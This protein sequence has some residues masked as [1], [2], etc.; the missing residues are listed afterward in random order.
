LDVVAI[1]KSP[2]FTDNSLEFISKLFVV[3]IQESLPPLGLRYIHLELPVFVKKKNQP[4][5]LIVTAPTAI[6]FNVVFISQFHVK[7]LECVTFA[8]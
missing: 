7:L 3:F 2:H 8:F 5:A 4:I 6:E 1:L